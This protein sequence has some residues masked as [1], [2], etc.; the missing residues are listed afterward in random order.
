ME[1]NVFY[2]AR[3]GGA[4]DMKRRITPVAAARLRLERRGAGGRGVTGPQESQ[5]TSHSSSRTEGPTREA[6]ASA[7]GE[8]CRSNEGRASDD[9]TRDGR[10]DTAMSLTLRACL[11]RRRQPHAGSIGE[12]WAVGGRSEPPEIPGRVPLGGNRPLGRVQRVERADAPRDTGPPDGRPDEGRQ[13]ATA[14]E[15]RNSHGAVC[16]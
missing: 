12:G 8:V 14:G 4:E 1:L 10:Q 9:T 2:R 16:H 11:N 3:G 5:R 6:R 7:P 15:D 13:R